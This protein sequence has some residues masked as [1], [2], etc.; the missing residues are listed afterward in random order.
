MENAET[1]LVVILS[2]FLA[3][4]LFLGIILLIKA[5]QLA[6]QMKRIANKAEHVVEKA[7]SIGDFFERASGTFS[8][9]RMLSNVANTVFDQV[10]K[11]KER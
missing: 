4:F 5:L 7:E 2:S 6:S 3:I 1:I 10:K 11:R 9:G 8:V